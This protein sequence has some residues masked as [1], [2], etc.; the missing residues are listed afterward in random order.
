MLGLAFTIVT[1]AILAAVDWVHTNQ[2]AVLVEV[3]VVALL[4]A[5]AGVL[6]WWQRPASRMGAVMLGGA[7]LWLLALLESTRPLHLAVLGTVFETTPFAAFM[8][9]VLAFPSGRLRRGLVRWT[10]IGA[11]LVIIPLQAPLY[12]F[13]KTGHLA[14]A[15]RPDLA[16][17]GFIVQSV[18]SQVVVALAAVIMWQRVRRTDR[19]RRRI[20]VPLYLY[21]IATALMVPLGARL[22]QPVFHQ[23]VAA[24]NGLQVAVTGLA[25]IFF[26]WAVLH[27]GFAQ[28]RELE[29]LASRLGVSAD[30]AH[31]ISHAVSHTLGDASAH[32]VFWDS[33]RSCYLDADGAAVQLSHNRP[34]RGVVE[35]DHQGRLVGAINYDANLIAHRH[36][37]RAVGRVVSLAV[38][39]ERLTAML[40]SRQRTL[41]ASRA[42][43]AEAGDAER[44]Q[45][46]QELHDGLQVRLTLLRLQADDLA[47][48]PS[49]ATSI[50]QAGKRLRQHIHAAEFELRQ[51][52]H[53]VMPTALSEGGLGA[54]ARELVK[55]MP[56]P[57]RLVVTG[58]DERLS[59]AQESTGYFVVAEALTNAVKHAMA[60]QYEV[61][62]DV[63]DGQLRIAVS[64][65]GIGGAMLGRGSGLR[66]LADRVDVLGGTM[67]VE[68]PPGA[69]TT[70]TV[71]LP[72]IDQDRVFA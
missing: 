68:S 19:G 38:E 48:D 46:A 39:N 26:A 34:Q 41:R 11:Y 20:L 37:V 56:A 18:G 1:L 10:V 27:G 7:A 25:P 9:L 67:F 13:G 65:D 50:R 16:Q 24:T 62:L 3:S 70:L 52:V 51:I 43:L 35:I 44:R 66:S 53:D 14:I 72:H 58:S 36:V 63:D 49:S 60:S 69:G 40:R 22:L 54:A 30:N 31:E 47:S 23:S 71:E 32:V 45:L 2:G 29:D 4:Y 21:A 57:T 8:H 15:N 12:L 17:Y 6:A 28:T 59:V 33:E 64:D 5:W 42:R 55:R 61:R